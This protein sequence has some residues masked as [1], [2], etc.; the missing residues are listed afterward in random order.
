MDISCTATAMH[1]AAPHGVD[2]D[3]NLPPDTNMRSAPRLSSRP[4]AYDISM[5]PD[6][7]T[8]EVLSHV[9]LDDL[10]SASSVSRRWHAAEKSAGRVASM[11]LMIRSSI[12]AG[13]AP[14][15][16]D[17][18]HERLVQARSLSVGCR[19]EALERLAGKLPC[20]P[21]ADWKKCLAS[22][23]REAARCPAPDYHR[24]LGAIISARVGRD[25]NFNAWPNPAMSVEELFDEGWD[26]ASHFSD[27]PVAAQATMLAALCHY[28]RATNYAV[29]TSK[30]VA[31]TALSWEP[32]QLE[33]EDA[34]GF[35]TRLREIAALNL[36]ARDL[37]ECLGHFNMHRLP[38]MTN[39]YPGRKTEEAIVAAASAVMRL[40]LGRR[41]RLDM[42][43]HRDEGGIPWLHHPCPSDHSQQIK[44]YVGAMKRLDLSTAELAHLFA[45][46]NLSG[47]P[48]LSV[49]LCR[50]IQS[51]D[52]KEAL[53]CMDTLINEAGLPDAETVAVLRSHFRRKL[54]VEFTDRDARTGAFPGPWFTNPDAS[55]F[56]GLSVI[57]SLFCDKLD[58]KME[59]YMKKIL[60]S[61]LPEAVKR[62]VLRLDFPD[63][64]MLL[65]MSRALRLYCSVVRD[66][67]LPDAMKQELTSPLRT[68]FDPACSL[69]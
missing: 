48:L 43:L 25:G 28:M 15:S 1:G 39:A 45:A 17:D 66:S 54:D 60:A 58:A 6:E 59:V 42:L 23:V 38:F 49:L 40:D 11:R 46:K 13:S 14:M 50:G 3:H 4:C 8:G 26:A 64:S 41:K 21:A 19:G 7:L 32:A 67:S 52:M 33:G 5:L 16:T 30:T 53:A 47:R 44:A 69:I 24:V 36:P 22:L 51:G 9:G 10:V 57:D 63:R 37:M 55:P 20:L 65:K 12:K 62:D 61:S 34:Y 27:F 29:D 35:A 2:T 31:S 56:N 68:Q 18:F